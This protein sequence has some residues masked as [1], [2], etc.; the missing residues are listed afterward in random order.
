MRSSRTSAA[1]KPAGNVP[2]ISGPGGPNA[3]A[4]NLP[5]YR[6]G[7][8]ELGPLWTTEGGFGLRWYLGS[9]NEPEQWALQLTSD[10]M[11]TSFLDD[12]YLTNRTG[13][14][15]AMNLEAQW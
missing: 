5:L 10:A 6:T 3:D 7:D 12:L 8:R 1:A 4:F 9:D 2:A 13:G 11:Y 14:L 15:A